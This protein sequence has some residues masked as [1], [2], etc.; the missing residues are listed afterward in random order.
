MADRR[1]AGRDD[2]L[3]DLIR[4]RADGTAPLADEEIISLLIS[5][6]FAG[7]ETTANLIAGALVLLLHRP[8]L[9]A[10]AGDDPDLVA[11]VVE[12]T[13]RIDAPV[14]GMFRRAVFDVQ[15]SGVTIPAGTQVFALF[16][17]A[18]R[19]GAAFDRPDEFDP[20]RPD[21]D[22]H[23]AFGRGIHFCLGAALARME[24]Q[25]ALSMLRERLPALRLDP[26]F[27]VPYVPNLMHR[28]PHTLPTTW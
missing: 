27:R 3:T 25:A 17:A 11:A 16:A 9:W 5:L 28:G 4:V 14:Q 24:A 2:L 26:D 23:L 10:A 18:N 12:E 6:V 8:E 22:R 19:D 13:L 15:V 1:A 7:H 21:K 20:E